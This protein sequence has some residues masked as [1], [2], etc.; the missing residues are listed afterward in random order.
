VSPKIDFRQPLLSI[1]QNKAIMAAL[2]FGVL[3]VNSL[4][5]EVPGLADF[6]YHHT[7][8]MIRQY[9]QSKGQSE[10]FGYDYY[11]NDTDSD[12]DL[13]DIHG[14]IK[15]MIATASSSCPALMDKYEPYLPV[16]YAYRLMR[17]G[18]YINDLDTMPDDFKF[19]FEEYFNAYLRHF[20]SD[21]LVEDFARYLQ[22][23]NVFL[24]IDEATKFSER[25]VQQEISKYTQVYVSKDKDNL[26][27]GYPHHGHRD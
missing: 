8:D 15:N 1:Q 16:H 12:Y 5:T 11:G 22:Y 9:N 27:E 7:Y 18:G 26:P 2:D 20:D 6:I 25:I 17:A 24:S 4:R 10:D 23:K 13:G 21:I 14:E 3:S 19:A